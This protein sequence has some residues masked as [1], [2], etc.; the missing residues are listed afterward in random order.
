M[1]IAA[2]G[3]AITERL[4]VHSDI[5]RNTPETAPHVVAYPADDSDNITYRMCLFRVVGTI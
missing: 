1:A 5:Y 3:V 4:S 2:V